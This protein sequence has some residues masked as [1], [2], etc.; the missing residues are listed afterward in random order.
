MSVDGKLLAAG[1]NDAGQLGIE[2]GGLIPFSAPEEANFPGRITY[3]CPPELRREYLQAVRADRLALSRQRQELS[4]ERDVAHQKRDAFKGK[5]GSIVRERDR[6]TELFRRLSG[7]TVEAL[8]LA[9]LAV[10]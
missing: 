2:P 8:S 5:T 6:A 10:L 4:L 1:D 3:E 7:A 9:Q